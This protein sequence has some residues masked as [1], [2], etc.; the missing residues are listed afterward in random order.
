[1]TLVTCHQTGNN[2]NTRM[3]A[4]PQHASEVIYIKPAWPPQRPGATKGSRSR[5]GGSNHHS[6]EECR[7]QPAPDSAESPMLANVTGGSCW[8]ASCCNRQQLQFLQ[9]LR[10]IRTGNGCQIHRV[11]TVWR[12][13]PLAVRSGHHLF[14]SEQPPEHFQSRM[15]QLH[16]PARPA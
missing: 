5:E 13:S 1:M 9:V 6:Q 8:T 11:Q 4:R 3:T 10:Q 2:Y 16:R 15:Q 14:K 12:H 7:E